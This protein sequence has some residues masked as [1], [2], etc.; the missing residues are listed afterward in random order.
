MF[1]PTSGCS[2]ASLPVERNFHA[3][4]VTAEPNP[5]VATCGGVVGNGFTYL[6]SCLVYNLENQRWEENMMGPLPQP[7]QGHAVVT[8][9]NVGNYM[10]GG[11]VNNFNNER[12]TDFLAPGSQKWVVG[13]TIP[14]DMYQPCAVVISDISFLAIYGNK[15]CEYQAN[16][17][18][19]TSYAGWV[20][21]TKWPQLQFSR[22]SGAGCSCS[23]IDGKVVVAGGTTDAGNLRSTEVLDLETRKLEHAE[24]LTTPRYGM[25]IVTIKTVDGNHRALAL[26]GYDPPSALDSVEEFDPQTLRWN[27]VPANLLAGRWGFGVV[28]LPRKLVC[29]V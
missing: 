13:P 20:F 14:M 10:I 29:P 22:D 17:D 28:A 6:A 9:K 4:F 3:L 5:R 12:T 24:D 1:P 25:Q 8:L 19:P 16:T 18:Q 27:P 23:K 7:R 21:A 15:I 11:Y 2:P 26:A